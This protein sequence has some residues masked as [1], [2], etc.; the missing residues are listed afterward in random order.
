MLPERKKFR[1]DLIF[2]YKKY[3][4]KAK[5]KKICDRLHI[6]YSLKGR[7]FF[8]SFNSFLKIIYPQTPPF[9]PT[10]LTQSE[11]LKVPELQKTPDS[12]QGAE[13]YF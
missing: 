1:V 2:P 8:W 4:S 9:S 6:W 5:W 12:T 11:T 10:W 13:Y 7:T 3:L